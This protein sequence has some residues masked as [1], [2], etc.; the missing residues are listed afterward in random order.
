MF[1]DRLKAMRL[2]RNLTQEQVAKAIGVRKQTV[3]RWESNNSFP[4]LQNIPK[5]SKSLQCSTDY[6][7]GVAWPKETYV[8]TTGLT[9]VQIESLSAVIRDFSLM[10]HLFPAGQE[11]EKTAA[12]QDASSKT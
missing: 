12:G 5:L 4:C 2:S 11:D 3:S 6:L 9:E 10:N 8:E 1:G 7:L